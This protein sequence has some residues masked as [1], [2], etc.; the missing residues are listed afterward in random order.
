ML[1]AVALLLQA[2]GA[3]VRTPASAPRRVSAADS[4]ELVRRVRAD[5]SWFWRQWRYLWSTDHHLERVIQHPDSELPPVE[6]KIYLL[7]P[8]GM[9]IRGFEKIDADIRTLAAHVAKIPGDPKAVCPLWLD[10]RYPEPPDQ[11]RNPD[12]LFIEE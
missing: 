2:S 7:E 4:A 1:L 12:A 10:Q 5:E 9:C 8:T 6:S 3:T 11:L